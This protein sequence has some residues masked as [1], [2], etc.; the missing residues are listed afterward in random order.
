MLTG[1]RQAGKTTV[2]RKLEP[3]RRFV[4]LDDIETRKLAKDDPKGFIDRFPPPVFID[5]FQ[6]APDLLPYIKMSVDE[7]RTRFM[8]ANGDYWLSGSQNFKMMEHVSESLA[9]RVAVLQ[10][11]GFSRSEGDGGED[12]FAEVPSFDSAG[13]KFETP[14]GTEEIFEYIIKGDKPELWADPRPEGRIYY[15]SYIQTYLE[16]DVR[17]QIGVRDLGLFEKFM[18]LLAVR[19]GNLLNM[20]GLGSDVGVSL[21]TIQR[22][23]TVLERSYQIYLL[24]PYYGGRTKRYV[25]TPKVYFLDTGLL[26]YF[27]KIFDVRTAVESPMNGMLFETW[28]VSELLKSRWH[29]GLDDDVLFLRTKDGDEIDIICETAKG[30]IAAEVKLSSSP[31]ADAMFSGVKKMRVKAKKIIC[32]A[33]Q[34]I[35]LGNGVEIVSAMSIS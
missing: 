5:E 15:S 2:L 19:S 6:Y 32:T 10:L 12:A 23:I 26:S 34:N 35:P 21:P 25:K 7:K 33:K 27:L 29:R 11:L 28:V 20:A 14:K 3:A 16:R 18:R 13:P 17:N 31:A 9:G 1:S 24:R 30:I 8:N 4:T 22:W